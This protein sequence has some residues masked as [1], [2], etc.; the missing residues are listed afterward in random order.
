[1]LFRAGSFIAKPAFLYKVVK[2]SLEK[3]NK[4]SSLKGMAAEG[5]ESVKRLARLVSAFAKGEYRDVSKGN[6][7]LVVAGLLYFISPL[8][9]IP[10]AIPILGY[11]DDITLISWI[12]SKVSEELN[13]FEAFEFSQRGQIDERSFQELFDEA[14]RKNLAGRSGMSRQELADALQEHG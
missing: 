7:I 12:L 5:I 6:A 3:S 11:L 2:D 10:D 13:K 4:D 14:Q 1:M 9:L 8:D